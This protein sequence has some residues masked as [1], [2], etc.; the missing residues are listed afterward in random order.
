MTETGRDTL[1]LEY[2]K[3][4]SLELRD[5]LVEKYH[6]LVEYVA[7]KLSFNRDDVDDLIQVGA[8]GLLRAIDHYDPSHE[9]DFSTFATP[10][11]IGE[12][13]HYFRDKRNVVK[14]PRKLQEAG[15]R[16]K[17][18]LKAKQQDKIQPTV[19]DIARD[20][21]LNEEVV[22][23]AMEATRTATV[24]SL[25]LPS[26]GEADT[27]SGSASTETIGDT[28]GTEYHEEKT[29]DKITL[30]EIVQNLPEREQEIIRLRFYQGLSQREIADLLGLSQMH[31]SRLITQILRRLRKQIDR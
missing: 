16:I 28:L 12:I 27:K 17:S 23:E 13:R 3:T 4:K 22:L 20:L 15:S 14:I 10:N 30:H 6:P 31:I 7:R 1:I 29:L 21:E 11:I 2:R 9:T 25:D 5:K 8:L 19:A 24:I 26:Y 18:Y